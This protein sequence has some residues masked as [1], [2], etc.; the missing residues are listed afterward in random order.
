MKLIDLTKQ[1]G[2]PAKNPAIR[3]L[4]ELFAGGKDR[5]KDKDAQD[6]AVAHL[7]RALG[8]EF[9]LI[10]EIHLPGLDTSIPMALV[11]PPGIFVFL[12]SSVRGTFRARGEAW[13]KL[14]NSGNMRNSSP[15][16][17]H[18]TRLYAEAI[19]KFLTQHE[20]PNAEIEAVLLFSEPEAFVENIKAPIRMVMCDGMESYSA[21]LRLLNP[22]YSTEE[23]LAIT[24]LLSNP[25]GKLNIADE[26]AAAEEEIV[27]QAVIMPS[28]E[29]QEEAIPEPEEQPN[30]ISE[31]M[32]RTAF[33]EEHAAQ[34]EPAPIPL[35]PVI[36]EAVELAPA[37]AFSISAWLARTHMS[38]NQITLLGVMVLLDLLVIL[39]GFGIVLLN[40]L[41]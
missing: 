18:L 39:A 4:N 28:E 19:R 25:E 37:G 31:D 27:P 7:E 1:R 20:L 41:R 13:L 23:R 38:A 2:E 5:Q 10:R 24:R 35:P 16:L 11:G 22:V 30:F 33:V 6:Q 29:P 36:E 32:V 9:T 15:N 12:A 17:P 34:A 21:S 40:I 14:D 26:I 3:W 8:D